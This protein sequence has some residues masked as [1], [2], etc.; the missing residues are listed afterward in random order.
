MTARAIKSDCLIIGSGIGG[1]AAALYLNDDI[2]VNLITKA[3]LRDSSSSRAQ[4]G[5]ACVSSSGDSFERHVSD[6]LEAGAGL[7]RREVV[8]EVIEDGPE[9]IEDLKKWG[10]KFSGGNGKPFLGKEGGHSRRRILYH[11][12]RT[13][14]ELIDRLLERLKE[15]KNVN[16]F[17]DHSAVDLNVREKKC[18][19]AYVL[20]NRSLKVKLFSARAVIL[21]TGGIGKAYLYTTNP[22][23]ATGDG[24]CMARR[25][26]CR[27]ANME[28]IQFHPTS[29][30]SPSDPSF[31][32]TEAMRGEGAVLRN[33]EGR[34][35]MKDYD[36]RGELAPRDIVARA[37]DREMK[38]EGVKYL[39]LDISSQKKG[40]QIR[41]RFP[42]I[43][44][45]LKGLGID[46]TSQ[47]I[48]IV[49]SAH[50]CCGGI[51]VDRNGLT[52]IKALMAVGEGSHTGLHGANRLASNS[53]L[54]ALVYSKKA[55]RFLNQNLMDWKADQF[56]PWKY[57]GDRLPREKVFIE[58][59]WQ[60][61]RRLMWNYVGIVRSDYRLSQALK[62]LKIIEEEINYYYW[63]YLI[64]PSL[65][66]LRNLS[67]TASLVIRSAMLRKE[68]RGL[69]YNIDHPNRS[70][71]FKK[72]TLI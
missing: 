5:I 47:Y 55:A 31:L 8:K 18:G 69:H 72:D 17:R 39:Y 56:P 22:D 70:E 26:G 48:P 43:Y 58:Q 11:H 24:I 10:F 36:P 64:T 44:S 30:Y 2:S 16:I 25:A 28:F 63:N 65:V 15:K 33:R 7:C 62:R 42:T 14:E 27:P 32:I 1:L 6:T 38:K 67:E 9:R 53:L 54:E 13:G 23:T 21:A 41:K 59:N 45:R 34:A 37:I 29:L 68:S 19:G 57:T 4:G 66:E 71:E 3:G 50:Y 61:I 46:I 51:P 49:P 12:D 35:F 40:S 20:E 60:S 52:E